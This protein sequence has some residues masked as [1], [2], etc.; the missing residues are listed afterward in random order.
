[1]N[2][3][4]APFPV[5][6]QQRSSRKEVLDTRFDSDQIISKMVHV[7]LTSSWFNKFIHIKRFHHLTRATDTMLYYI[8]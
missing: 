1:M 3:Q 8:T 2:L 4:V 5:F 6:S 7:L